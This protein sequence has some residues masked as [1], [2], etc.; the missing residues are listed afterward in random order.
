MR[1]SMLIAPTDYERQLTQ[2]ET[3]R[4]DARLLRPC[5][6]HDRR[7]TI[8]L[9]RSAPAFNDLRA[10]S[11]CA[12]AWGRLLPELR[13]PGSGSRWIVAPGATQQE[14]PRR[15]PSPNRSISAQPGCGAERPSGSRGAP[16]THDGAPLGAGPDVDLSA[17][18]SHWSSPMR[19]KSFQPPGYSCAS[20]RM[21]SW[22]NPH[23]R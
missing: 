9:A 22:R 2:V 5:P 20:R 6:K 8:E 7:R 12:V 11:P 10:S 15:R 18:Y 4:V 1:S 14:R 19:M 21:P 16:I 17:A 13:G 3:G 23:A